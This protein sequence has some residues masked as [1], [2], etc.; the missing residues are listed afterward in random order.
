MPTHT[1]KEKK[2]NEDERKVLEVL[3][4]VYDPEE[5]RA[6]N[7][8]GLSRMLGLD[9]KEVRRACRSLARKG[10]AKYERALWNEDDGPAGAGYRATEEGAAM[11]FPCDICGARATFD[12]WENAEGGVTYVPTD[13]VKHVRRCYEHEEVE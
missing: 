7:F 9:R 3:A 6:Y 8:G 5:W 11:M 2:I 4:E 1:T 13:S 12:W 10:L